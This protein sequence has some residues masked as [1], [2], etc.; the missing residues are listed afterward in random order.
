MSPTLSVIAVERPASLGDPRPET[1]A[2]RVQRLQ[3]EA[4][5]LADE[6]C[7]ELLSALAEVERLAQEIAIQREP[8]RPG[9]VNEARIQAEEAAQ[10]IERLSAIMARSDR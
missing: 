1:I 6:H 7:R 4:R 2:Q 10:R 9:I 5:Q 8:Y 3:A